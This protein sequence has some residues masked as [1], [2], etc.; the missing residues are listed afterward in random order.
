MKTNATASKI[1]CIRYGPLTVDDALLRKHWRLE[2]II[3]NIEYIRDKN[4][5]PESH[6]LE[7]IEDT[8]L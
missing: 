3:D 7:R 1:R 5:M 6:N 8:S 4:L 2:H